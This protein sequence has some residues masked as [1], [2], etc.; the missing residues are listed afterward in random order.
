MI[1]NFLLIRRIF[2]RQVVPRLAA[3]GEHSFTVKN[4]ITFITRND[5]PVR[6]PAFVGNSF[7]VVMPDA[8]QMRFDAFLSSP[9]VEAALRR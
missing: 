3:A 7:M 8:F 1:E 6:A 9:P 5:N 2:K 4:P